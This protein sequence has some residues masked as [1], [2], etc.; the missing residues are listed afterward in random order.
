MKNKR[1][2]KILELI[3]HNEIY[4]QDMLQEMLL[5]NGYNVTQATV[6]R[7]IKELR[8]IKEKMNNGLSKYSVP[9]NNYLEES[10]ANLIFSETA[11]SVD[12]AL[13]TVVVKCHAGMA[14][15]ACVALDSI[16]MENIV[17]TIAGD[18]TIFVLM[19]TEEMAEIF[20][21]EI[22]KLIHD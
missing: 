1:H 17:G 8:L 14:Q 18:D 19:R 15:A 10:Q 11:I 5:K 9:K 7:D 20:V 3:E 13:N 16:H 4:T 22:N 21:Q 2:S 12:Y 6:S